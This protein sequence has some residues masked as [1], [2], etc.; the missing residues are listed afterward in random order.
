MANERYKTLGAMRL[1]VR[2]QLDEVSPAFW[3]EN[4]ITRYIN[5]AKDRVWNRL[6]AAVEGYHATTRDSDDTSGPILGET[7]DP[8]D[9]QIVAGQTDYPL[10]PDFDT[11]LTIECITSGF[12]DLDFTRLSISDPEFRAARALR[13]NQEPSGEVYYDI[14]GEPAVLRIAPKL[15]RTLDVRVTYVAALADLADDDADRLILPNPLYL[16]VADYAVMFALRQDRSPDAGTYE[17][18]GDKIIAEKFGADHRQTQDVNV[19]RA[20]LE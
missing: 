6:K 10:P 14:I 12:E 7:Y 17:A 8:A 15:S 11:L 4:Q 5:R 19:A 20:Y 13:D 2:D 9:L 1:L 3:T 18:S 16:A